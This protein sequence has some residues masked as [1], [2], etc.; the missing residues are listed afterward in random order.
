MGASGNVNVVKRIYAGF[1]QPVASC[2]FIMNYTDF[3][4]LFLHKSLSQ[5]EA[6]Y[7]IRS[8]GARHTR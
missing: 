7:D 1:L 8:G 3:I 5:A 2:F 6:Y 4:K